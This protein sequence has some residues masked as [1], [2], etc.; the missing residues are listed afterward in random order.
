MV[1]EKAELEH[2]MI[3]DILLKMKSSIFKVLIFSIAF[4][5]V[6]AAVVVYLRNLLQAG[7]FD[8]AI[9]S[10]ETLLL[11]PGIA[12]LDPRTA[13]KIISNTQILSIERYRE[14]ATLIM[15]ASVAWIS[16]KNFKQQIAYFFFAFGVWD[17][18]YYVF[19][20]LTIGWPKGLSDLDI[21]FLLPVP[22]VGPVIVPIAISLILIL[23]SAAYLQRVNRKQA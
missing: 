6:E 19:L 15:L 21:F 13:V 9:N 4:A 12:F 16:G 5:F 23:L 3:N 8:N 11:I 2:N 20:R 1:Y 14:F 18:F 7:A 17:I 10:K 22:W